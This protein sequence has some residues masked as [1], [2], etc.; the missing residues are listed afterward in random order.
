MVCFVNMF[1]VFLAKETL[2]RLWQD[3]EALC[4]SPHAT[5]LQWVFIKILCDGVR[6][7]RIYIKV[8]RGNGRKMFRPYNCVG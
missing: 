1:M 3:S 2:P 7:G 8:M 4:A 6:G 5:S